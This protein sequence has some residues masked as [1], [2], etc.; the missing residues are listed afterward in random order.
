MGKVLTQDVTI[1][2]F[3]ARAIYMNADT[4]ASPGK[5]QS[6][7][8]LIDTTEL[9]AVV[10]DVKADNTGFVLY[11]SKIDEVK[12]LGSDR[13]I[14]PDLDA[15]LAD[16]KQRKILSIARISVFWD[17][18]L[19]AAKPEWALKSKKSP[20]QVWADAY[21]KHWS[22]PYLQEVWDYNIAIA[23]EVASRGFD[24]V[25]FDNAH[26]PSDGELDDI[27][28]GTAQAGR[29]RTDALA[30][31]LTAL[32]K[33]FRPW[34]PTCL[35]TL[36]AS[37]R[38]RKTTWELA[39]SSRSLPRTWTTYV[40]IFILL[41]SEMVFSSQSPP[42]TRRAGSC[43]HEAGNLSSVGDYGKSQAVAAR[44]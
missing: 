17:Q 8:N 11:D 9:S 23:K 20:G 15:L 42:S 4:V 26:F 41:T 30:G 34:A 44:L 2:P 25:L 40:P 19:V 37:C 22:N 35:I 36:S 33:S 39:N 3:V 38:G 7:L 5:L 24:E 13:Q 1:Q 16:L 14:I 32:T 12:Q 28:F 18:A 6:L 31:F 10:I 27:D 43:N 21:G 29:K